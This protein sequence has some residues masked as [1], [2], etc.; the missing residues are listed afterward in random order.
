MERNV[1]SNLNRQLYSY[2]TSVNNQTD[3]TLFS[4][5]LNNI[6]NFMNRDNYRLT[7]NENSNLLEI[8]QNATDD[9]KLSNSSHHDKLYYNDYDSEF[10]VEQSSSIYNDCY[11]SGNE[12]SNDN[13]FDSRYKMIKF[14]AFTA[15][16]KPK[17]EAEEFKYS[18]QFV[19]LEKLAQCSN[20]LIMKE[21]KFDVESDE[22]IEMFKIFLERLELL[23]K[24]NTQFY[25][26]YIF[27]FL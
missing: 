25:Y 7:E 13:L 12:F 1:N 4:S 2:Q 17:N 21:G 19:L 3:F 9:S 14:R 6:N 11:S 15:P 20:S 16:T 24:V 10:N 8:L 5:G 27:L 22:G 26:L 18:S 23:I